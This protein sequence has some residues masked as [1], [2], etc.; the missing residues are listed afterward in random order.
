MLFRSLLDLAIKFG[1][2]KKV[3]TRIELP[4]GSKAFESQI[5]KDPEKYFTNEVLIAIDEHC[6]AEFMYGKTNLTEDE[7]DGT[8]E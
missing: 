6:K 2:F 4:D 7:E 1:I 5:E 8:G 3:S